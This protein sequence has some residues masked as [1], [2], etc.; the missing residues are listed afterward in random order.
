MVT[1]CR[2]KSGMT[3]LLCS[4]AGPIMSAFAPGV[5]QTISR[6]PV[7][8]EWR[9]NLSL[10]LHAVKILPIPWEV[11]EGETGDSGSYLSVRKLQRNR[12]IESGGLGKIAF[13]KGFYIYVGSARKGLFARLQRHRRL[14]KRTFWRVDY[15]RA[16]AEVHGVFPIRTRDDLECTLAGELRRI[17]EWEIP[18]FGSSDCDCV[19]HLF[20]FSTDPLATR[21]FHHLV[22]YYR[23]DRLIRKYSIS[24]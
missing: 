9:K 20:G 10:D 6:Y 2:I 19:S 12:V 11:V 18:G 23:A 17:C 14:R 15:L 22:L 8:V 13:D 3:E 21:A 4:V 16:E 5:C 24:A 1:G 7:S